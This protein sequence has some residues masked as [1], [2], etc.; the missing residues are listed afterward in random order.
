MPIAIITGASRGLGLELARAL[1]QR[2]WALIIDARGTTE[3][4]RVARELGSI[5]EVVAIPGDVC[6]RLA[7]RRARR[8]GGRRDRPARQQRERARPEPAAGAC[9]VPARRARARLPRQ[10]ARAR[11]ARAAGRPA[12]PRRGLHHQRHVRRR[13]RALRGLGWLRLLQGRARAGHGD[14][15]RR[16]AGAARLRRR[17]GRHAHADAP[18]GVPRRGHLRSAAARGQRPGSARADRGA[19]AER[20]LPGQGSAGAI[21]AVVA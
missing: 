19:P 4:E 9:P 6:R 15:R 5:T 3:L 20:P 14:P 16:A 21:K 1:A 13:R 12:T 11:R 2:D 8:S 18:G 7:P 17:P 10:R